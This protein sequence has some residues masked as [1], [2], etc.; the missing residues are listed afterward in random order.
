[1]KLF[2]KNICLRPSCYKCVFKDLSRESDIS[3][4]DCWGIEKYMPD[5]DDNMGTSVIL[6]HS[7]LGQKLMQECQEKM[8]FRKADVD[9]VLPPS[10]DF[11]KIRPLFIKT[12]DVSLP[13]YKK[14]K[15]FAKVWLN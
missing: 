12:E 5:M 9:L 1:M 2:L 4:G 8:I 6:V 3:I 13:I 14:G 7:E 10:A 15:R 11:K